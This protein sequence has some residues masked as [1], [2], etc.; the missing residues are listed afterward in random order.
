MFRI[1]NLG[2]NARGLFSYLETIRMTQACCEGC[3]GDAAFTEDE[4]KLYPQLDSIIEAMR[5]EEMVS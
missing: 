5:C 2:W 1:T 3:Q 4:A